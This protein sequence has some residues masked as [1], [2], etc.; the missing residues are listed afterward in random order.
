MDSMSDVSEGYT[1]PYSSTPCLHLLLASTYGKTAGLYWSFLS[2]PAAITEELT[3][4]A[5]SHTQSHSFRHSF[6]KSNSISQSLL[7]LSYAISTHASLLARKTVNSLETFLGE[8]HDAL[9]SKS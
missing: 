8:C 1:F 4:S 9:S 5:L 2:S 3:V 6:C 7:S